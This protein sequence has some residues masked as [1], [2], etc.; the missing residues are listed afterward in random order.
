MNEIK[1]SPRVVITITNAGNEKK[2][3]E[4]FD[5]SGISTIFTCHGQGTAPSAM[6]DLFGL[7]GREKIINAVFVNKEATK[8]LFRHLDEKLSFSQKGHGI[9][10]TLSPT[11]MQKKIL[12]TI[13]KTPSQEGDENEMKE[14]TPYVAIL[15]AVAGGFS[16]EVV[17]SARS[18]GARGGTIIKGMREITKETA[19]LL[20]VS[21]VEE[22]EFVLILVPTEKKAVIMDAITT[23]CGI[24][25]DAHGIITAFP[26]DEVFGL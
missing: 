25:T 7:S 6:M 10:F 23:K 17:E 26:T 18:A 22:Q 12:E 14:Q 24:N 11:S 4:A 20:R 5:L 19:E 9:A 21:P 3:K 1:L 2:I 8:K 15:T 13:D 16:E